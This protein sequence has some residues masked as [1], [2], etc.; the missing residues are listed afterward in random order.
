MAR[1]LRIEYP[2]AVYHVTTRG[3]RRDMVFADDRDRQAFLDVF[4]GVVKRFGWL[5]HGYCLMGNHYHLLIETPDPNL[6]LG[7]RQINGVYT[8]RYN[9]RHGKSGH[10]FQGRYKAVVV[11]KESH[12][13]ELCRYVPLNPVRAGLAE[14]PQHWRWSNYRATGGLRKAP[15][16]L[17]TEWILQQFGRRRSEAQKEYRAFVRAGLRETGSPWDDL[18][19]GLLLGSDA[20]I[21]ACRARLRGDTDLEEIPRFERYAGR[22]GLG[23]LFEP[24]DARDKAARNAAIAAAYLDHGYRMKQ[25]ADFLGLHYATMSRIIH[26]RELDRP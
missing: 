17:D 19:G 9:V 25:I 5:C 6:S 7:M 11:E 14:R 3:N 2:G 24:I 13:L 12:L 10:V 8:Q 23:D 16:F 1:P 26:S 22:P 15:D 4:S 18:R 21:A 20:F